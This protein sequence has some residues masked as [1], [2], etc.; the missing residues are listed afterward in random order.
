MSPDWLPPILKF[1]VLVEWLLGCRSN[2]GRQNEFGNFINH[3]SQARRSFDTETLGERRPLSHVIKVG[4]IFR[5]QRNRRPPWNPCPTALESCP[6]RGGKRRP[7]MSTR[8][9][10]V[11]IAVE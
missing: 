10:S 1:P 9:G 3:D 2:R 8:F 7:Q 5:G 4:C 11:L 6:H